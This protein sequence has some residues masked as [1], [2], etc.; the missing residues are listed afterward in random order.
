MNYGWPMMFITIA[1]I[2]L[3]T[4]VIIM[5]VRKNKKVT[6]KN[7]VIE[8]LKMKYVQGDI[9]EEEYLKR[10]DVLEKDN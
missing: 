5:L 8:T 10:K 4:A 6:A 9:T 3:A 7:S 2:V 1:L